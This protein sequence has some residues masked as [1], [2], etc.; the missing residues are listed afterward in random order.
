MKNYYKYY[1]IFFINL[2]ISIF[3]LYKI[4]N[5]FL[6]WIDRYTNH[7]SYVIVPN[8]HH[9][10]LNKAISI[11]NNLG[12]KYEIDFSH[13]NPSFNPYQI[14][15]FSPEA[16]DH[17]K[18]GRSIYIQA[19]SKKILT[20]ILPNIINKNKNIALDLLKKNNIMINY[21]KYINDLSKDKILK[22]LY[23]EK[24]ISS[25][26]IIPYKNKITL[27]IGNGYYENNKVPNVIGLSLSN[28]TTI[29]KKKLFNIINFYYDK[30][31]NIDTNNKNTIVY[32]QDPLPGKIIKNKKKSIDLWITYKKTK[33]KLLN[34]L[35]EIDES[36]LDDKNTQE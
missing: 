15:F 5:F 22:V 10:H 30:T 6:N 36:N 3:F 27:I 28:A 12:L 7:G 26:Y 8:I 23:K 33:E 19:N 13:Y 21:I 4:S 16:G 32:N 24:S 2:L 35:I 1:L 18:I 29:L 34:N 17:V 14:I 31:L 11:L 25:G 20:T 9:L